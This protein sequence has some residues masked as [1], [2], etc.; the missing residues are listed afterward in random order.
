[1]YHLELRQFPHKH[2]RFNLTE[3][4]LQL[5]LIPWAHE[6]V[7]DF[8]ERKWNP[9]Q[10][11]ITVLEGPELEVSEL[12][13]GRGWRTAER[14]GEDV[15]ERMLAAARTVQIPAQPA[16]GAPAPPP[17]LAGE[18]SPRAAPAAT[19]PLADPLAIGVQLASLLGANA[20]ALLPAW[21]EV[22][23]QNPGLV[24]SESLAIAERR[25]AGDDVA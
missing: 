9:Q 1:V 13:M 18:P 5:V 23:A 8:G 21:R 25:I 15:T 4:Q 7:V 3:R 2:H 16:G 17:E 12:S 6:R 24:P 14:H 11:T 19:G 20:A 10:A 22:A